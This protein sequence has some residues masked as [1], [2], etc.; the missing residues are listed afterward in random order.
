MFAIFVLK[1][2]SVMKMN[3][4]WL[5][6]SVLELAKWVSGISSTTSEL[7]RR[8][9][10]EGENTSDTCSAKGNKFIL[11]KS[12]CDEETHR[13]TFVFFF[14]IKLFSVALKA[15]LEFSGH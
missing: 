2:K 15:L 3:G 6:I 4:G 14:I 10:L 12:G 9:H 13:N 8:G 11:G 1:L 5:S 7:K